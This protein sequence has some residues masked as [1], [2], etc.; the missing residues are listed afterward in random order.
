MFELSD[1]VSGHVRAAEALARA[2]RL[3]LVEVAHVVAAMCQR[4]G[5]LRDAL[6]GDADDYARDILAELGKGNGGIP[7]WSDALRDVV[8]RASGKRGAVDELRL[9]KAIGDTAE[10]IVARVIDAV[11][12]LPYVAPDEAVGDDVVRAPMFEPPP[13]I[14]VEVAAI[15][16]GPTTPTLDAYGRDL[17]AEAKRGALRPAFGRDDLYDHIVITLGRHTKP[18]VI[19]V[20]EAGVGKTAIAEG[21]GVKLANGELPE[22]AGTRI[23]ALSPAGLVAGASYRGELENRVKSALAEAAATKTLLFIDEIHGLLAGS[24]ITAADALKP[25]LATGDVRVIGA[26]TA[27]EYERTIARDAALARRFERIDVLEP[28]AETT[29]AILRGL[30]P[31]L[32]QHHGVAIDDDAIASAIELTTRFLPLRR[33]PDKAIDVVDEACA[34]TRRAGRPR[35]TQADIAHAAELRAGV[36]VGELAGDQRADL[37]N[38]EARIATR[39]IGQRPAIEALCRAIVRSRLGLKPARKPVG[40]ILLWGPSGV[41]KTALAHAI[42]EEAFGPGALLRIDLAEFSEGHQVSR[43]IGAP[44]GYIGHDEDGVLTAWLR[45]KPHSVVL[46]DEIDKA[47]PRVRELLLGLFDAGRVADGRGVQ[48]SGEHALFVATGVSSSGDARI[49]LGAELVGRLDAIVTMARLGPVEYRQIAALLVDDARAR[50][51]RAQVT[52]E[53]DDSVLD[54]LARSGGREHPDAPDLGARPIRGAVERTLVDPIA[55]ILLGRTPPITI[56]ATASG[57]NIRLVL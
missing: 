12:P 51:A 7:A 14:D 19:L 30:R 10:G 9:L 57:G 1:A 52:L 45:A 25:A 38:L 8:K 31:T 5:W 40:A 32:E 23:V 24:G 16:I 41:G 36:A 48:I 18:H 33:Q 3:D 47:H 15:R 44:P 34:R 13:E 50:L 21:L 20:G 17:I 49:L 26:T 35:V 6:A 2:A 37:A 55:N 46:L 56:R 22:L 28:D 42:A 11:R 53:V 4:P 29:L 27:V 39:V 54:I 43:L